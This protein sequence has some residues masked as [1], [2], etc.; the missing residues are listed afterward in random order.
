MPFTP[1][2]LVAL[3]AELQALTQHWTLLAVAI[4]GPEAVSPES[5]QVLEASGLLT[6]ELSTQ[7]QNGE[8]PQLLDDAFLT[9]VLI[10]RLAEEAPRARDWTTQRWTR[11][12]A[13]RP[14]PLTADERAALDVAKLGVGQ[15]IQG[16]GNTVGDTVNGLVIE[17]LDEERAHAIVGDDAKRKATLEAIGGAVQEAVEGRKTAKWLKSRILDATNDGARDLDRIAV[18]ESQNV[19]ERGKALAITERHGADALVFKRPSPG[20][21][22][23]CIAA[24]VGPDG[25]PRVFTLRELIANGNNFGRKTKDWLPT[26][27][28]VH[29]FCACD[30]VRLPDGWGFDKDGNMVPGGVL[31]QP[32]TEAD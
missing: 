22:P 19:H 3:H 30:L 17:A 15:Y 25:L 16:L 31:P 1:Q 26:L 11:E 8:F 20:A 4:G 23:Q 2:Q 7:I 14:M 6:P 9:G 10:Q 29:P 21:C 28:S 5:L 13:K 18:T 12:I 24:F 27:E 32:E